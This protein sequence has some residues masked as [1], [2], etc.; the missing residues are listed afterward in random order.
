VLDQGTRVPHFL[1]NWLDYLIWRE[2][3]GGG[4]SHALVSRLPG[5]DIEG[6]RFRY[7]TSVEHFYPQHPDAAE[8]HD[9]LAPAV[10]N[11]F[12]NLA[13]MTRSENSRRSNLVPEAKIK[14]YASREQSLKFQIMAEMGSS[15]WGKEQIA[16]H[17]QE[18]MAMLVSPEGAEEL[19]AGAPAP[20]P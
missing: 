4:P 15:G 10:L 16:I 18:C 11:S 7:R 14:Q 6:F 17:S 5:S 20:P 19:G 9:P 12:G 13:L 1:F 2:R 3:E 8:G